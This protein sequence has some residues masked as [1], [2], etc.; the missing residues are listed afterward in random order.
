MQAS[1]N[2][3][4]QRLLRAVLLMAALF[5]FA[6]A[7]ETTLTKASDLVADAA[8]ARKAGIP[9]VILYS[10]PGCP[11]CETIRASHLAPLA[12]ETPQRAIVRQIDLGAATSLTGFDGALTSHGEFVRRQ[13][14]KFAPVVQFF[15][16][17]GKRLG[18]PLVGSMLPDFYGAY[19]ADALNAAT[20]AIQSE[21]AVRDRK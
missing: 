19:L 7:A 13:S 14:I 1:H 17:D 21:K 2:C 8:L 16:S 10:L 12:A 15:N 9:I 20:V 4:A 11:Y 3:V 5:S 18:E 6:A